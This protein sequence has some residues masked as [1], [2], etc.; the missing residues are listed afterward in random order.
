MSIYPS[1]QRFDVGGLSGQELRK[2]CQLMGLVLFLATSLLVSSAQAQIYS[3]S[4]TGV[5]TDP[6]GAVVPGAKVKLTDVDKGF[7]YDTETDSTGGYVW[8]MPAGGGKPVRITSAPSEYLNPAWSRDGS[9]LCY[10]RGSGGPMREG[11]DLNDELW[12][13][14]QW[15]SSAGGDWWRRPTCTRGSRCPSRC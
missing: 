11:R 10:L 4:L 13:E 15:I 6:S 1:D 3:G 12:L 8:K 2:T 9:R 7:S 5:V 14:L